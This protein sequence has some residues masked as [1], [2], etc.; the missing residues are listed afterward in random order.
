MSLKI[1]VLSSNNMSG[2]FALKLV[3]KHIIVASNGLK[4]H[5]VLIISNNVRG[6]R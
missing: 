5:R 6:E 3:N 2:Y 4:F 1:P